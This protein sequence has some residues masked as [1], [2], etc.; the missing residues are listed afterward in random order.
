MDGDGRVV[1]ISFAAAGHGSADEL[2]PLAL[3]HEE[4]GLRGLDPQLERSLAAIYDNLDG[5]EDEP[6]PATL[7]ATPVTANPGHVRTPS[8]LECDE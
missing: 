2:I 4:V 7:E 1:A 3:H 5:L 8:N 6:S